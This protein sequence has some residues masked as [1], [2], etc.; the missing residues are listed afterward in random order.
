M[1][2]GGVEIVLRLHLL[3]AV[4][5]GADVLV[6]VGNNAHSA[7]DVLGVAVGIAAVAAVHNGL[8]DVAHRRN[9]RVDIVIILGRLQ[10]GIVIC[11]RLHT[12]LATL[13]VLLNHSC[14]FL[15]ACAVLAG[16]AL[17][18]FLHFSFSSFER[19]RILAVDVQASLFPCS[20]GI[21]QCKVVDFDIPLDG[22]VRLPIVH[23]GGFIQ[24]QRIAKAQLPQATLF[25][26]VCIVD[27]DFCPY[28]VAIPV[29]LGK[30]CADGF[31]VGVVLIDLARVMG[32]D[33][34]L[35]LVAFQR[36]II[37]HFLRQAEF[38]PNRAVRVGIFK[39]A[40]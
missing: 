34:G 18:S 10:G 29:P 22:I 12:L 9:G 14:Q 28:I 40:A 35:T 37:E 4:Q 27:D 13:V 33:D 15:R 21:D 6:L 1:G 20:C 7:L 31:A 32:H 17:R 16:G 25:H 23:A 19:F 2:R 26:A 36:L 8:D 39:N 38:A 5:Q 3:D 30:N 11:G 24:R